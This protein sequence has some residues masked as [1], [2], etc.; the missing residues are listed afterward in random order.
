MPHRF[1]TVFCSALLATSTLFYTPAAQATPQ[2]LGDLTVLA[3][4]DTH[5]HAL[6]HDY[7]T[8]QPFGLKNPSQAKGMDRLSSAIKQIRAEQGSDSVLLLDNGDANQGSNLASYYQQSRTPTS[9]DPMAKVLNHLDYD[10]VAAGNHE[11]N[12]GLAALDQYRNN[13]TMPFLAS[14]VIDLAS[15]KPAYTPYTIVSKTVG[16]QPV[17]I[18][19][20]G[21]V[22][23]RVALWDNKHVGGKLQ[24]DDAVAAVK[25]WEPVVKD[26]G[27]DLV[28][29]LA[30]TGLDPEGADYQ[31]E[32]KGDN[33]ARSV[34]EQ[35]KDVDLVIGGHT[36][37]RNKVEEFFTNAEGEEVLYTQPG[38]WA[39][40]LS[41]VS[42]PLVSN[43]QT[44]RPEVNWSKQGPQP[45]ARAVLAQDYQPDRAI[46]FAAEPYHSQARAWTRQGGAAKKTGEK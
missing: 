28:I 32:L 16:G 24:F 5:A 34:A 6:D 21:V 38:Y 40:F 10:A 30:H 46:W 45:Q 9:M 23:P 2:Q 4:T 8:D 33:V 31:E 35:T 19:V 26:A 15:G 1:F 18:G 44:G 14:N 43:E 41:E 29:V 39:S 27:A 37:V 36:H 13:L 22:T 7:I 20:I 25:T 12:Y 11:F 3:T 17:K 42:L